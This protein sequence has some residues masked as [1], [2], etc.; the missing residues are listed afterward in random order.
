MIG[1]V[2][3]LLCGALL[4]CQIWCYRNSLET[5]IAII[6]ATADFFIATKRIVIM[7]MMYFVISFVAFLIWVVAEFSLLGMNDF[8]K[9]DKAQEK[10]IIWNTTA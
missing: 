2:V 7:S 5:A 3:L 10:V 1:G 9:G 4:L 6:D 8:S